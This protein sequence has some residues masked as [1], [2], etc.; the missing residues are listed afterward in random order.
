VQR[1][2]I[3]AVFGDG[4]ASRDAIAFGIHLARA[5]RAPLML[6]AVWSS[7]LGAG[8]SLY[9]G[10]VLPEM[11]RELAALRPL[12]PDTIPLRVRVI[13]AT[14]VV[15][16]LHRLVEGEGSDVIVFSAADLR[17]YGHGNLALEALHD[18]PCAVAVVP[19]GYAEDR[20]AADV[21]LGWADTAEARAALES[22][23][24]LVE[25]SGGTL[26][27]VHV[28]RMPHGLADHGWLGPSG[29]ADWLESARRDGETSLARAL[30][31]VD[32]RV[33][34]T[35]ELR[36]GVCGRELAFAGRGCGTIVTGSRGYGAL[37]RLVLGS[38]TA[39]LLREAEVPVLT[40]PRAVALSDAEGSATAA[41]SHA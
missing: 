14:S 3:V 28:L 1:K 7:P 33:P 32:G 21:A 17:H 15:R 38:T 12:V 24:R 41:T 29:T 13:G 5:E 16:G 4:A 6:A 8:D 26:R 18:A 27:I 19:V 30:A 9:E 36:E 35:W 20:V 25:H 10:V 11:E 23:V 39:E 40:L 34:A 2:I 31:Q 22:G 37:R